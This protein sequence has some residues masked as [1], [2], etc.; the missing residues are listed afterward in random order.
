MRPTVNGR[1]CGPNSTLVRV[2]SWR[3][4]N[5][6]R[7]SWTRVRRTSCVDGLEGS[8]PI[9]VT[10]MCSA[11]Y[12][13]RALPFGWRQVRSSARCWFP[14][15][16][17]ADG[18]GGLRLKAGSLGRSP[19]TM[20]GRLSS[21]SRRRPAPSLTPISSNTK[22]SRHRWSARSVRRS[23]RASL[24][25]C[26]RFLRISKTR[27]QMIDA[28]SVCPAPAASKSGT[29]GRGKRIGPSRL[30]ARTTSQRQLSQARSPRRYSSMCRRI[31]ACCAATSS[32][33]L[34]GR[35]AIMAV[36]E[37]PAPAEPSYSLDTQPR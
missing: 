8:S 30:T 18:S 23:E 2:R 17:S 24:T 10:S 20:V 28:A 15:P 12:A 3:V 26:A 14:R 34:R 29:I 36:P 5:A 31:I 1:R 9:A 22:P 25:L 16:D 32:N 27:H 4:F 11:R 6:W 13:D 33:E 35:S 37:A 7:T 19:L 21:R